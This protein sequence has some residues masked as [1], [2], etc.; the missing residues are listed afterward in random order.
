MELPRRSKGDVHLPD[1][2]LEQAI[3][4]L[5]NFQHAHDLRIA[6]VYAFDYRTRMLPYWYADKRMAPCSVR[7]LADVLTAAGFNHVRV[8]LQQWTPNFKPSK[9][10]LAGH[11][12]DI[13]MTS[14]MQVHA[15]PSYA[16]VRDACNMGNQRPLILA[17]GPKAIYEPTDYLA[18][19][20]DPEIGADCVVTGEAFVLLDLFRAILADKSEQET[21][22]AAFRRHRA[23]E[24]LTGIPGLVYLPDNM[25]VDNPHAVNTGVQRLLRNLDELP[26]PDA[27]YRAIEPPHRREGL[28]A[29]PL[30]PKR[31]GKLSLISSII[32]THGCRFTCSFCPIPAVN[33][34]TWRHKSAQRFA[35]EILHIY[36]NFGIRQF[37]GT[38]DNFFN[39][40]ETVI[41]LMTALAETTTSDG[42]KLGEKIRFFTEGTQFDVHKNADLLPLCYQAGMRAIWFGIEDITAEVVN[43]GQNAEQARELFKVM[44]SVGIEPMAMLIHSDDQ[45]LRSPR[46]TLSGL[47]NQAKYLFNLGAVSYQCT[48]LGPAIG[49]R[50]IETAAR[51]RTL[52]KTVGGEKVPEAYYD[53]N[54]VVASAH[55]QPW[56]KQLNLI[57]G[58]W[59]FYNPINTLRSL[60]GLWKNGTCPSRLLFQIVGQIGLVMTAPKLWRWSRR[61][62]KEPIEVYE[63]LIKARLPMI[64]TAGNEMF[65]SVEQVP[66]FGDHEAEAVA[67]AVCQ[68]VKCSSS[69]PTTG[70]AGNVA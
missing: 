41:E 40:R 16:L 46:G 10:L 17:G 35:Q 58:Y 70:A 66:S 13:V 64:D 2:A 62:R 33:Q 52:Y 65:W 24:T 8:V 60:L 3:S 55:P 1:G 29:N 25:P 21:A 28:D 23:K 38:D 22:L 19:G 51:S 69:F 31:V 47:I 68:T 34:K 44:L 6:I 27:G 12:L 57:R 4:D 32:A 14:A 50:D 42:S 11:P 43:K 54:H 59:A 26:L 36:E 15:E 53:G 9:A 37:F 48:Y 63:G 5:R 18:M 67:G 49:T 45:P 61:L 30:P 39:K 20:G 7:V 56:S